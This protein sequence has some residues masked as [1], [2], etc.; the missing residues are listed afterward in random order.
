LADLIAGAPAF[1]I[2]WTKLSPLN[3]RDIEE[4]QRLLSSRKYYHDTIDGRLGSA[5]RGAIGEY[6]KAADLRVDCW[7]SK[8]LLDQLRHSDK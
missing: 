7:P 6:Q 1:E 2:A 4:I 5:T 8:N 3:G